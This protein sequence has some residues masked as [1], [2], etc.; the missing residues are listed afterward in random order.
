MNNTNGNLIDELKKIK[1]ENEELKNKLKTYTNTE[2]QKKYYE[3]NSNA[4]KQK[5]KEYM[6]KIKETNPE[7]I[8]EWSHNAYMKRKAKL[9]EQKNNQ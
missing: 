8:K 4:I 9:Q 7:K 1:E 3:N 6:K 2:R 5:A